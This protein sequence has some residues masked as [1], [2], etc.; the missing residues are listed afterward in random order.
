MK[1]TYRLVGYNSSTGQ[2]DIPLGEDIVIDHSN[3]TSVQST[4]DKAIVGGVE[5]PASIDDSGQLVL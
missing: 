3:H 5:V 4:I 2:F 1:Q